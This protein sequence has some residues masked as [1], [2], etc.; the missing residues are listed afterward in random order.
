MCSGPSSGL[1]CGPCTQGISLSLLG[2]SATPRKAAF[3]NCPPK[4]LLKIGGLTPCHLECHCLGGKG[5]RSNMGVTYDPM[6]A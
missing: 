1:R 6:C 3:R 5:V 4:V 2:F